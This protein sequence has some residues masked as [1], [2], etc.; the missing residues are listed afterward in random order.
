[1]PR[2]NSGYIWK[3]IN[4]RWFYSRLHPVAGGSSSGYSFY[5]KKGAD[6]IPKIV[7]TIV[8]YNDLWY[9]SYDAP[10]SGVSMSDS[11][12]STYY[13]Y[14]LDNNTTLAGS[15]D[16]GSPVYSRAR[17]TNLVGV[18]DGEF[19]IV[20][21]NFVEE[22]NV[23][24]SGKYVSKN[25]WNASGLLD[26]WNYLFPLV[27]TV[28]LKNGE[29]NTYNLAGLIPS[30]GSEAQF[31]LA[32]LDTY[33][34]Y[35]SSTTSI[36]AESYGVNGM[37]IDFGNI[38]Q[39]CPKFFKDKIERFFDRLYTNTYIIK[40]LNDEILV[41]LDKQPPIKKT[42]L[43][44]AGN[45]YQLSLTRED[46]KI[47]TVTWS[48]ATPE[49]KVFKGLGLDPNDTDIVIPIGE[50]NVP[51]EGSTTFY[52]IFRIATPPP[53]PPQPPELPTYDES[54]LPR[55]KERP[56]PEGAYNANC[57]TNTAEANRVD[58]TNYLT[59]V[60]TI[61]G[62]LREPTSVTDMVMT[63]Q[64]PHYPDFN[65]IRIPEL[66]RYYF[67]NDITIINANLYEL[68]LSVDPLMSYKDAILGLTA[69][70]DRN[71]FLS[72]PR[73]IDKKRVIEQGVDIEV[74]EINN[75]VFINPSETDNP[76]DWNIVLNGYKIDSTEDVPN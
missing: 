59:P 47:E 28:Y 68:D 63:I 35:G 31:T 18:L 8:D 11:I 45:S 74:T 6:Y 4:M 24:I 51:I 39:N 67:V 36:N 38:P 60:R 41:Q 48:L 42:N 7:T 55:P 75:N 76:L 16:A 53:V 1:M 69:F 33:R 32:T 58:K 61:H 12:L 46:D 62:V 27:S 14:I 54:Q 52:P 21:S 65:Y 22:E 37:I 23:T 40:G 64:Y 20:Q 43:I 15:S 44:V 13:R 56:L 72:N 29:I 49:G 57:Y 25:T 50:R 66:K 70:V 5:T 71:E 34:T 2:G 17:Y 10:I 3:G 26:V 30:Y 19:D 9:G 73:I